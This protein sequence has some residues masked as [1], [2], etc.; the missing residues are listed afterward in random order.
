[1][2]LPSSLVVVAATCT[3]I[4][5]GGGGDAGTGTTGG[6][7]AA[8]A[9][10]AK[11]PETLKEPLALIAGYKPFVAPPDDKEKYIPKRRPVYE[12]SA[13]A[14][15]NEIRAAA[16][17]ARQK[18]PSTAGPI[19]ADIV[20]ALNDVAGGCADAAD[21]AAFV[22]CIGVVNALDDALGKA[23]TASGISFGKV[24]TATPTD[25]SKKA[26]GRLEKVKGP[27]PIEKAFFAK[28]ADAQAN[29]K[30]VIEAC[31]AA[32]QEVDT[33]ANQFEKADEPIRVTAVTHKMNIDAQCHRL[34][35]L[36]DL[37]TNVVDCKKT[38]KKPDC[39]T[40]CGKAKAEIEEGV[41]A[42]AF[43]SLNKDVADSC[44]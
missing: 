24:A 4:S 9:A 25:A 30:A 5:C 32:A 17:D 27:G 15:A 7:D 38:P 20:Q 42:A 3:L 29:G 8:K 13:A 22:K 28:R 40:A 44:K 23:Q 14:A 2:R 10:L 12:R 26:I 31:Q 19:G 37:Q 11:V 16:N 6:D 36:A 39:L 34:E 18:I 33:I 41:P 43:E 35:T 21:D 1:M